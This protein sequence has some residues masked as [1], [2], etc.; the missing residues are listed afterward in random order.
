MFHSSEFCNHFYDNDTYYIKVS[1]TPFIDNF[2]SSSSTIRLGYGKVKA[3]YHCTLKGGKHVFFQIIKAED[4]RHNG[5][6]GVSFR[7]CD[8][9]SRTRVIPFSCVVD[10]IG[11]FSSQ[12]RMYAM[13]KVIDTQKDISYL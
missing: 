4:I 10:L 12:S 1:I 7:P 3:I 13:E 6:E 8:E 9:R 11:C 5:I 2:R